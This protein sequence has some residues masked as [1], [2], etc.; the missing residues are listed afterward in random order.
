MPLVAL[1]FY[2]MHN[3]C[4]CVFIILFGNWEWGLGEPKTAV[5]GTILFNIF[6]R[7]KTF[8]AERAKEKDWIFR[9]NDKIRIWINK[10]FCCIVPRP[11]HRA[12]KIKI[13]FHSETFE[14]KLSKWVCGLDLW[15]ELLFAVGF[16][17]VFDYFTHAPKNNGKMMYWVHFAGLNGIGN[18]GESVSSYIL[19]EKFTHSYRAPNILIWFSI[20]VIK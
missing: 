18:I 2:F 17:G 7:K 11:E 6:E 13:E 3:K 8:L 1:I 14:Y 4:D 12:I 9:L 19:G 16:V 20:W 5:L 10:I 15:F